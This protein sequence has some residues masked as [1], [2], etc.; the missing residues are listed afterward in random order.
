[1][2]KLNSKSKSS[3]VESSLALRWAHKSGKL[4]DSFSLCH[5]KTP[6]PRLLLHLLPHDCQWPSASLAILATTNAFFGAQIRL[7][8]CN[9]QLFC[10]ARRRSCSTTWTRTPTW[11]WHRSWRRQRQFVI[12]MIYEPSAF[13]PAFGGCLHNNNNN[14]RGI[15]SNA[16]AEHSQERQLLMDLL[17]SLFNSR[18]PIRSD[19]AARFRISST[20]ASPSLPPAPS[21]SP[22]DQL[23]HRGPKKS[24]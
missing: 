13:C 10:L 17:H 22:P 1:M 8:F 16:R 20:A 19:F 5:S 3:R 23:Q 18:H 7:I 21:P 24:K 2:R 12:A 9:F 14:K 6:V 15:H 11:S 4:I